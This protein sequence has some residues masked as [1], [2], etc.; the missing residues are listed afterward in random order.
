[1]KNNKELFQKIK[2]CEEYIMNSES[3]KSS[4][5]FFLVKKLT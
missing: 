4:L 1:M 3:K 5:T 2:E